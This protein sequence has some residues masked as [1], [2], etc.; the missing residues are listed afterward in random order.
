MTLRI[1]CLLCLAL[2]SLGDARATVTPLPGST[3]QSAVAG[4][5]FDPVRVLVSDF[6]GNPVSGARVAWS[7]APQS[8]VAQAD[9]LNCT[10][11]ATYACS[12]FTG[13]NGI[14]QLNAMSGVRA[15]AYAFDVVAGQT[16]A[17]NDLGSARIELAVEPRG[18]VATL[19]PASGDGQRAVIGLPYPNRF[20]AR[21]L[22]PDG[23]PLA[24]VNVEF[25]VV[26]SGP[27]GRFGAAISA[28]V[29]TDGNGF[30]TSP[31][32][33]AGYG[34]GEGR[35]VAT[36]FDDASLSEV[37]TAFSYF[38]T[39]SAGE[40]F[41]SF[42][43]MWWSGFDENGWGMSVAQHGDR[44]FSV[45]YAYDTA[46]KPTWFVKPAG[47]WDEGLGSTHVG[48][49]YAP[50]GSPYFAYEPSRFV[51][52]VEQG[53]LHTSFVGADRGSFRYGI[54]N[55][56]GTKD[57][58]RQ[59]YRTATPAPMQGLGDMWWGGEFQPGWGIAIMEQF[60]GLFSVWLTYDETGDRTW[61]V[62]PGGTWTTSTTF[63]G[64]IYSTRGS[65][66]L[67]QPYDPSRLQLIDVGTFRYRFAGTGNA[68]F[69]F[70]VN[71]RKGTLELTRQPF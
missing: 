61:F 13:T 15:G 48:P 62:M 69:D 33:I 20:V 38:N 50:R 21:A 8:A 46:G 47:A 31:A 3:P 68:R 18:P 63:E 39:T 40:T 1:A 59:D 34:I 30:A 22:R 49:V 17:G 42:Q 7:I 58:E 16:A 12:V 24:A 41:Q 2:G 57:I 51:P 4:N 56:A 45:I 32:F 52:G 29:A 60:G 44:L 55:R 37:A 71:C 53:F 5:G 65:P 11:G 43:D 25:R 67:G 54:D 35:I 6:A 36:M 26:Q 27:R 66:W 10:L 19:A 70:T 9:Y 14:A 23:Q 28:V 64:R